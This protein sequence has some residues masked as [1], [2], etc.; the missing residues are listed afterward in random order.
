MA[1]SRRQS[2][3]PTRNRYKRKKLGKGWLAER[4]QR[5]AQ[6]VVVR[7]TE[8]GAGEAEGKKQD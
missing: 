5:G 3:G 2:G 7:I 4:K 8:P 6:R 1:R